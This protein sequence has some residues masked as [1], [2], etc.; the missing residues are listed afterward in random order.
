MNLRCLFQSTSPISPKST[1]LLKASLARLCSRTAFR[2][3]ARRSVHVM[4]SLK[5]VSPM[6]SSFSLRSQPILRKAAKAY[7][8]RPLLGPLEICLRS[9][10][11]WGRRATVCQILST[12]TNQRTEG[13]T[14]ESDAKACRTSGD[15]H[16]HPRATLT[17]SLNDATS[18][19]VGGFTCLSNERAPTTIVVAFTLKWPVGV[20]FAEVALLPLSCDHVP[21]CDTSWHQG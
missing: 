15:P 3:L 21:F 16:L 13:S 14:A 9:I 11:A 20:R 8:S 10:P 4:L 19:E 7:A 17:A 18:F 12:E 1:C 5:L 2:N 6:T